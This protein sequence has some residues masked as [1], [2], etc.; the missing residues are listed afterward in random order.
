M[1][2]LEAKIKKWNWSTAK[3]AELNKSIGRSLRWNNSNYRLTIEAKVAKNN[4]TGEQSSE[5]LKIV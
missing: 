2:D 3:R 5:H 4:F 1:A